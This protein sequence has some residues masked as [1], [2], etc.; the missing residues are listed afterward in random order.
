MDS[1]PVTIEEVV[2]AILELAE[3]KL[4]EEELA[5]LVSAG[6]LHEVF[7]YRPRLQVPAVLDRWEDVIEAPARELSEEEYRQVLRA[8]DTPVLVERVLPKPQSGSESFGGTQDQAEKTST[9]PSSEEP[10]LHSESPG[11]IVRS[12]IEKAQLHARLMPEL[13]AF[14]ETRHHVPSLGEPSASKL[15]LPLTDYFTELCGLP[16]ESVTLWEGV[17]LVLLRRRDRMVCRLYGEIP[18][19]FHLQLVANDQVL[20]LRSKDQVAVHIPAAADLL[21]GVYPVNDRH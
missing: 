8:G 14:T 21:V 17:E 4:N 7:P 15:R 20:E 6:R 10:V 1:A 13:I 3:R 5:D 19:G 9:L 12:A 18:E 16:R 11:E 2:V